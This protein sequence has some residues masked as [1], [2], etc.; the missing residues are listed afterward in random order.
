[1]SIV[2][3]LTEE[4]AVLSVSAIFGHLSVHKHT[5]STLLEA[6]VVCVKGMTGDMNTKY[7][8]RPHVHVAAK[9]L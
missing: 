2:G 4:R 8:E 6:L 1:M 9:D 5:W 7:C 3:V